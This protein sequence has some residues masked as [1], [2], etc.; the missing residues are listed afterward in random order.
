MNFDSI[1]MDFSNIKNIIFDL[2]DVIINISPQRCIQ[3]F[4]DISPE[5]DI[6]FV[7]NQFNEKQ[8]FEK[9]ESGFINNEDFIKLVKEAI[10]VYDISDEDI[11][12]AW[13]QILLDIPKKRIELLQKLRKKYRLFILSNTS[14]YHV[15]EVNAILNRTCGVRNLNTLV[16]KVY[17]SFEMGVRKPEEMIYKKVIKDA[18]IVPSETV[19]LDDNLENIQAASNLEIHVIHVKKPTDMTDYLKNA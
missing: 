3:A 11:I 10:Q 18:E 12:I 1:V 5:L 14:F 2:G 17:Y 9:Y 8:I 16:D 4:V 15:E 7:R 6:D 19:F 13:Q